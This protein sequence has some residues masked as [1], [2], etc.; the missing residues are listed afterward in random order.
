MRVFVFHVRLAKGMNPTIL[1]PAMGRLGSLILFGIQSRKRKTLYSKYAK[2]RLKIDLPLY[3]AE[4]VGA[5]RMCVFVCV[6][7]SETF[8]DMKGI[9]TV[10]TILIPVTS[11]NIF[12]LG[13]L[14]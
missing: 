11:S 8:F 5:W 2:P 13:N 3:P 9:R 10:T 1:P 12:I 4:G 14:K 6:C 7:V